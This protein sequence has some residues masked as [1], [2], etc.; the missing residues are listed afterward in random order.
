VTFNDVLFSLIV[1]LRAENKTCLISWEDV[2]HWPCDALDRFIQLELVSSASI[3]QSVE[4]DA[5]DKHCFMD[6]VSLANNDLSLCRAF[7]VCDDADMQSQMGRVS[8]PL[9][10][11]QQWQCSVKQLAKIV[12][13]LLGFKD[14]ITV[15]NDSLIKLG[16]LKSSKGRRWVCLNT[17]DLSIEINQHAVFIEE[18]LF[19]EDN[20]LLI[21]HDCICDLLNREPLT[22]GKPYRPSID[23]REARKCE[24]QAM[25]QDWKDEYLRLSKQHPTKSKK[26]CSLQIAKMDIAKGKDAETIRKKM[27]Q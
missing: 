5:C 22:H 21:D 2:Q 15:V 18:I 10:K 6:V 9:E 27:I 7:I 25:Y 16:M 12:G 13:G 1:Q 8:I 17:V 20:Q 11:L 3:A 23:R 26:W 4:C 24:T 14:K 19:F